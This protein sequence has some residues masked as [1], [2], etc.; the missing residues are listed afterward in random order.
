MVI[1]AHPLTRRSRRQTPVTAHG[2]PSGAADNLASLSRIRAL[3]SCDKPGPGPGRS[4]SSPDAAAVFRG[5]RILLEQNAGDQPGSE[6]VRVCFC[7]E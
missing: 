6:Q 5:V 4:A 1:R 7:R 3:V 2:L